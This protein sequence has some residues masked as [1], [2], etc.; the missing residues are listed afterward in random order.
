MY[1]PLCQS[2]LEELLFVVLYTILILSVPLYDIP[3]DK[4]STIYFAQS[5]YFYNIIFDELCLVVSKRGALH[6]PTAGP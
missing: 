3:M 6:N 4:Y 1:A 5:N 2:T